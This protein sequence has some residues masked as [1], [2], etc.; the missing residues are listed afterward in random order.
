MIRSLVLKRK[1]LDEMIEHV[2]RCAPIE[3]CGLLAG[4]DSRVDCV[5][6]VRNREQSPV[7]FVMDP[8]E[9]LNALEWIDSSGLE[10]L[11]IFHSHPAGP[12]TASPTDIQQ[13]AYPVIHVILAKG[14]DGWRARGFWIEHEISEE[15]PLYVE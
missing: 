3:A 7:R 13:A 5:I 10:L 15:V 14:K 12:E 4:R 1:Q 9:Q 11:G 2:D 8:I 6:T